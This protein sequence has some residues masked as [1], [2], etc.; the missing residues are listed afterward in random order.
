MADL[1][2]GCCKVQSAIVTFLDKKKVYADIRS[3]RI[4]GDGKC[5][6]VPSSCMLSGHIAVLHT[7]TRLQNYKTGQKQQEDA[8][9]VFGT[10][11]GKV[12]L[13]REEDHEGYTFRAQGKLKDE[14]GNY[15][16]TSP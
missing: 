16:G 9:T 2:R 12:V 14:P 8:Q 7:V 6:T 15:D 4:C 10:I 11:K 1:Q 5:T 13:H 3:C